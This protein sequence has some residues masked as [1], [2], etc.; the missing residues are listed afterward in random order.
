MEVDADEESGKSSSSARFHRIDGWMGGLGGG[1]LCAS[2]AAAAAVCERL[3]LKSFN[4]PGDAE[5]GVTCAA[6]APHGVGQ[7]ILSAPRADDD[8]K[9]HLCRGGLKYNDYNS[10]A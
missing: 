8:G 9:R 6:Q 2:A 4:F 7:G 5:D 3:P 10:P 1:F